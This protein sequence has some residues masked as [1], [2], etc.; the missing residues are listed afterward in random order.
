MPGLHHGGHTFTVSLLPWYPCHWI[1][2]AWSDTVYILHPLFVDSSSKPDFAFQPV[3]GFNQ[4]RDLTEE[5][6]LSP[7]YT[8][9]ARL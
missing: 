1:R 3:S 7:V 5:S 9:P 6:S 8:S 2:G 4:Y